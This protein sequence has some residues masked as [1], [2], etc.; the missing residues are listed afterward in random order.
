MT[1]Q[2]KSGIHL[3]EVGTRPAVANRL[4]PGGGAEVSLVDLHKDYVGIAAVDGISVTIRQGEFFTFLGPSGSGKTTT[5]MMIAGFTYPTSGG[6]TIDGKSVAT[7]PPQNR[8]LGMVFQ[9]YAVFPHLTVFEN[10]GFPLQVRKVPRSQIKRMVDEMLDLV[11]LEGYADRNPGQLSGGEQQRVALARALV[12]K[13]P[14]LLM[15]E[16][17][18][19]LD[20][21]MREHMQTEIR[22][23][24][25]HLHVTVI[26]VT[27]D[28]DEALTMSDRIA[29]M[30]K[31]RIEQVGTP[32]TLY[33]APNT[34]FVAGFLG[35][36]NFLSGT[37]IGTRADTV[38]FRTTS[39]AGLAGIPVA[40]MTQGCAIV[41]AV[42]PEKLVPVEAV[43]AGMENHLTGVVK[44]VVFCGSVLR[45]RVR[46]GQEETVL[47][48]MPNREAVR[49]FVIGDPITLAWSV[50]DTR[51]FQGVENV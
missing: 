24:H 2:E 33:E 4:D 51:V 6:I 19:A 13:P 34:R 11:H 37:V 21:K 25:Q 31:G 27:H 38:C 15:D 48:T 17:L 36:S 28:Q 22:R 29:I 44:E 35:D 43:P 50:T 3:P 41:A 39:G 42:R 32:T 20:K 1:S 10:I 26:Y 8:G 16:P 9:N 7:L 18:G 30:K 40:P 5:I 49:R 14:V 47:L 12:F 23:I 46:V 45:Y